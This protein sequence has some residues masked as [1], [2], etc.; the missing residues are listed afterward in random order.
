M[1]KLVSRPNLD[2]VFPLMVDGLERARTKTSL[3]KYW[4]I[5]NAY[6]NLVNLELYGFYQE[7]SQYAGVFYIGVSPLRR[8]L[9]IFWAGKAPG[10]K[11]PINDEECDEF[12]KA[13]AE[14]F[15]CQSIS[16]TGR[17]GWEKMAGRNGYLEDSRTYIKDI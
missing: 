16:V 14:H 10:N 11:T 2:E 8:T 3:G 13:C 17:K 6:D 4:T 9:N 7:E 15:N 5:Q 1:I 12:F